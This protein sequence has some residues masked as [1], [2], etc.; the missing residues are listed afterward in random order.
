MQWF[1]DAYF[2]FSTQLFDVSVSRMNVNPKKI[3]CIDHAFVRSIVPGILEDR[4]TIV[5]YEERE[6]IREGVMVIE[7][8]PGCDFFQTNKE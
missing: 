7:V 4:G 6:T 2:L 3:Y 1:E 8:V 5:T